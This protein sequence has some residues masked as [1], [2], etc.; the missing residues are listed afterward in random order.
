MRRIKA[1]KHTNAPEWPIVLTPA[2]RQ[3]VRQGLALLQKKMAK[4]ERDL[5]RR[6]EVVDAA[7]KAKIKLTIAAATALIARIP[8]ID[9]PG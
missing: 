5:A 8:R 4:R 7:A 6:F 9:E 3:A 1:P 2:E